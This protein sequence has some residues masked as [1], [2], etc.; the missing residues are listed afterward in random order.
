[1]AGQINLIRALQ[2]IMRFKARS[3]VAIVSLVIAFHLS[4]WN[5]AISTG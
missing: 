4:A 3:Q 2:M 1:M 5:S